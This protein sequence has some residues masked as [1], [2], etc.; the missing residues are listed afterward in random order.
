MPHRG[1]L[2]TALGIGNTSGFASNRA[3]APARWVATHASVARR[4]SS[5]ESQTISAP[6]SSRSAIRND[7]KKSSGCPSMV[8]ANGH[9]SS[10]VPRAMNAWNVSGAFVRVVATGVRARLHS[11]TSPRRYQTFAPLLSRGNVNGGVGGRVRRN[12]LSC[13]DDKPVNTTTCDGL[14]RRSGSS[15]ETLFEMSNAVGMGSFP[16]L[17]M[18]YRPLPARTCARPAEGAAAEP[19]AIST[20]QKN[21]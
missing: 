18:A 3:V 2:P 8:R 20:C 12:S 7:A 5:S 14:M 6:W 17:G 11:S 10:K 1:H 13:P 15:C 4:Y 19:Q 9:V 16:R 21:K